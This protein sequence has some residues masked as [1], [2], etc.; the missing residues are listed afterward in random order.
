MSDVNVV[1]RMKEKYDYLEK[2]DIYL[3]RRKNMKREREREGGSCEK[4]AILIIV[5]ERCGHDATNR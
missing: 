1:Y 4:T 5:E 2:R 3:E